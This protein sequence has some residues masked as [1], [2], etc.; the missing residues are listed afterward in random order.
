MER[1]LAKLEA[2]FGNGDPCGPL[3]LI[4][5]NSWSDADRA[6]WERAQ[7][8]HD[9]NVES[10]LLERYA[11]HAVRPCRHTPRHILVIKFRRRRTSKMPTKRPAPRGGSG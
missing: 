10:E 2:G 7:I 11:G 6:A 3:A 5:P 9:E 8:L 1:R 4:A